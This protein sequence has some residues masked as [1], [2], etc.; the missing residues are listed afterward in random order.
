MWSHVKTVHLTCWTVSWS[1][2]PKTKKLRQGA[3]YDVH[4]LKGRDNAVAD[5]LGRA[6]VSHNWGCRGVGQENKIIWSVCLYRCDATE[7]WTLFLAHFFIASSTAEILTLSIWSCFD[8][9]NDTETEVE[10]NTAPHPSA[11]QSSGELYHDQLHNF[12]LKSLNKVCAVFLF[13]KV[14]NNS[15]LWVHE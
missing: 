3:K 11:D 13:V 6:E 1:K 2:W 5:D 12:R 9:Q 7:I 10:K 15:K 4:I 14:I 8:L